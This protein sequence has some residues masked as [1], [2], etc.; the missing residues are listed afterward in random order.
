MN[1]D[2]IESYEK[3]Y[4][5]KIKVNYYFFPKIASGYFNPIFEK[6]VFISKDIFESDDILF[7]FILYHEIGH[8]IQYRNLK[9]I[10]YLFNV[11]F[12]RNYLESGADD[13][14][15]KKLKEEGYSVKEICHSIGHFVL[16][17][18]KR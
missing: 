12:K 8:L 9:L 6:S 15:V 3:E 7:K 18:N 2:T 14:A 10:K 5:M 16:Q 11:L 13:F 4:N 1:L 17:R